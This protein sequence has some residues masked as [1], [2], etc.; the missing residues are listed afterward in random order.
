[1]TRKTA[2]SPSPYRK[3]SHPKKRK[4]FSRKSKRKT[5]T[6]LL[7]LFLFAVI[8][9]GYWLFTEW[10]DYQRAIH[11]RFPAFGIPLPARLP[12]HGI[13]VSRYQKR[14]AW[15]AVANMEVMGI[16]IGFSF[17]KATEGVNHVDDQF[18]RNWRSSKRAGITRGA[19]HY[20]IPSQSGMKQAR[21]FLN[22]VTLE[23]GDLPPVLDIEQLGNLPPTLIRKEA[24]I[25]LREVE[26]V[27][28][29]RPIIYTHVGFYRNYL[30]NAFDPY[31][32]WV[33]H[34]YRTDAPMIN[35]GWLFWQHHD[36]GT[37]NGVNAPVDFN[38][39]NGD[40]TAFY[41]IL[42]H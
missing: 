36:S 37:V 32:L 5:L 42:I 21:H 30:G 23:K 33:A 28:H 6:Y 20:F 3:T 19:Y 18:Y 31:P 38:V 27:C 10:Q 34:Y 15:P 1:M 22:E 24:L 2:I 26:R 11:S 14:I 41:H 29:I 16:R 17:I 40:S 9:T 7:V 25:W 12:I 39:F 8:G 13:D 4:G 35:R